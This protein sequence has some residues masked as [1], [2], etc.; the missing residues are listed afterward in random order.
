MKMVRKMGPILGL[1]AI[2]GLGG[3]GWAADSANPVQPTSN[4]QA[5]VEAKPKLGEAKSPV[6]ER[7]QERKQKREARK[8]RLDKS[9]DETRNRIIEEMKRRKQERERQQSPKPVETKEKE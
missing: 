8:A 7:R 5:K 6:E 9:A 3:T 1:A 2:M 4:Q